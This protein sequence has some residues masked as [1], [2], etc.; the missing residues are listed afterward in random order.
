MVMVNLSPYYRNSQFESM[1]HNYCSK[2]GVGK[3]LRSVESMILK[4]NT[5]FNSNVL[6]FVLSGR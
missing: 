1:N 6:M 2:K 3:C 4:P 5:D